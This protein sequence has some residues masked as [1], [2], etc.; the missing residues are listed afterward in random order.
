[1]NMITLIDQSLEVLAMDQEKQELLLLLVNDEDHQKT[2]KMCKACGL[3]SATFFF[4]HSMTD[5]KLWQ[6]LGLDDMH[7]ECILIIGPTSKV[8]SALNQIADTLDFDHKQNGLGVRLDL[9]HA[10]GMRQTKSVHLSAQEVSVQKGEQA[11]HDMIVTI[12]DRGKSDLVLDVAN[13]L[14]ANGGTIVHGR[15][16]AAKSKKVFNMEIEPEKEIVS[17]IVKKD[18]TQ[19]IVDHVAQSLKIEE[20]NTG[21]I[22]TCPLEDVRGIA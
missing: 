13:K 12:V 21:V 9:G 10:L 4:A 18:L 7:R 1:M 11:M 3:T 2:M 6:I 14:G 16:S 19:E 5:K 8:K 15:G 17:I 22:F 20:E